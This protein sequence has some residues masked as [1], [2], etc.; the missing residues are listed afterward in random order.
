MNINK[1]LSSAGNMILFKIKFAH[2]FISLFIDIKQIILRA[3]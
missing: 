2:V 3:M 1:L